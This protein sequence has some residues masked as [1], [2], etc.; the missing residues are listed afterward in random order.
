M[1]R[2]ARQG[3]ESGV[4]LFAPPGVFKPLSDT[5]MLAERLREE[6]ALHGGHLLDLCC[7]SGALAVAGG[8]AGAGRVTA[9]DRSWQ[10]VLATRANAR[11]NGVG[12]RALCGHLFEPVA[13]ER[14]DVIVSNPP[15]VPSHDPPGDSRAPRAAWD[16]GS[17]GRG[18]LDPLC[19]E[20]AAHLAPG[21]V[22][23]LVQSSLIGEHQTLERLR[24][25][26]LD[27]EVAERRRGELGPLMRAHAPSAREEELLVVSAR[28][29]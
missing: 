5:W 16:G 7:G 14:F 25:T 23:L 3:Y 18:L 15:Y 13:G 8:L 24:A 9:V 12:V 29:A 28:T 6:P 11:L 19:D 17:D 10:A 27:A 20:L 2:A 1:F 26:G 22:A 21:G 4:R